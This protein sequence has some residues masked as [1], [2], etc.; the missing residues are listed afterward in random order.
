MEVEQAAVEVDPAD[1]VD[2]EIGAVLGKEGTCLGVDE[3]E[4]GQT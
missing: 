4:I 2:G 1:A 3:V